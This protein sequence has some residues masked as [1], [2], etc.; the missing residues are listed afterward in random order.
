M[1]MKTKQDKKNKST[2]V[3]AAIIDGLINLVMGQKRFAEEMGFSLNRIFPQAETMLQ[4]ENIAEQIKQWLDDDND[5]VVRQM[6]EALVK[7]QLA[8]MASIDGVVLHTLNELLPRSNKTLLKG[9]L[10]NSESKNHL[11][12]LKNNQRLR[13]QKLIVPGFVKHY[14]RVREIL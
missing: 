13:Y 9:L 2:A 7:H 4:Q 10:T 6:F 11:Q 8:L 14:M 5:S 3:T 12:E 1:V